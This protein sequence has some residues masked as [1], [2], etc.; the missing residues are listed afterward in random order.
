MR[1]FLR[2]PVFGSVIVLLGCLPFLGCPGNVEIC[3][4]EVRIAGIGNCNGSVVTAVISQGA[5]QQ[6]LGGQV[7]GENLSFPAGVDGDNIS[8]G[9]GR[10]LVFSTAEEM[11]I[12]ISFSNVPPNCPVAGKRFVFRGRLNDFKGDNNCFSIPFSAFE[13]Q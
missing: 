6:Q 2:Y 8:I 13:E 4:N 11:Q 12:S 9:E 7:S 3:E 5:G 1:Y 10:V